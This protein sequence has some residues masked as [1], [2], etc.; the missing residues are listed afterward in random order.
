[1]VSATVLGPE[2]IKIGKIYF[3]PWKGP[4]SWMSLVVKGHITLTLYGH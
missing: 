4:P 1:M 2:A 3:L